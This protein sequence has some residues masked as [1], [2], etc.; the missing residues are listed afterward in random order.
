MN[1][2]RARKHGNVIKWYCDN[3]HKSVWVRILNTRAWQQTYT[4]TFEEFETIVQDDKYA[5]LRKAQV[6]GK[7]IQ[8]YNTRNGMY[9]SRL[10]TEQ[11]HDTISICNTGRVSHHRIKPNEPEFKVGDW[12]I[13]NAYGDVNKYFK[14]SMSSDIEYCLSTLKHYG[15]DSIKLWEPK[16]GEECIFWDIQGVKLIGKFNGM[17]YSKRYKCLEAKEAYQYI[18]PLEFAQTLRKR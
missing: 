6:D 2:A 8:F 10:A 18:A 1:E 7:T 11:W 16:K 3:P 5:D 12:V 9:D 14:L 4:P 13:I 17:G 15:I